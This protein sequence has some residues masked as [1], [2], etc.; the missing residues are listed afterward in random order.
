MK[1]RAM[2]R[3]VSLKVNKILLVFS[4]LFYCSCEGLLFHD[5]CT[6]GTDG[7][8]RG[9][10]LEFVYEKG[11]VKDTSVLFSVD[12]RTVASYPYKDIV[13]FVEALDSM[14]MS[15]YQDTAVCAV[16]DTDGHRIGHTAGIVYQ[17]SSNLVA[18]SLPY[19]KT[20]FRLTH[21]MA[22]SCLHDIYDVGVRIR[23]ED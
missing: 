8:G 22:D 4:L 3:R 17:Q 7:W 14:G 13:V 19:Q 2:K 12:T 21:L 1:R 5:F 23:R 11:F 15:F 10:T 20:R 6:I 18:L 9:D 16:Y